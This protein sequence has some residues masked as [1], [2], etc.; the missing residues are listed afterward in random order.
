MSSWSCAA[1]LL[2]RTA[3]GPNLA[4]PP[5]DVVPNDNRQPAGTLRDGVLTLEV[6]SPG[7]KW[8]AQGRVTLK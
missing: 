8:H 7:G 2:V 4:A 1:L 5:P 3:L 6:R